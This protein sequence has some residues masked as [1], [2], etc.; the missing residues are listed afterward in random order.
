MTEF[1]R[2]D[3][4]QLASLSSGFGET[5][6][7]LE[8]AGSRQS[9]HMLLVRYLVE[10]WPDDLS[11]RDAAIAALDQ[12][13][14]QDAAIFDDLMRDPMVGAWLAAVTRKI[15]RPH[16]ERVP[17][18]GD[19]LHLG[20]LAAA[21]ALR[22]GVDCE[23]TGYARRGR[24]TLPGAGEAVLRPDTDGLVTMTVTAGSITLAAASDRITVPDDGDCWRP[25]RQLTAGR[26]AARLSVRIEDGN[27]YRGTYHAAP[28]GRLTTGEVLRWQ[29][30]FAAA[31]DLVRSCS[32]ERITEL[33]LGLR[34]VVPLV[35]SGDGAARS[36]TARDSVGAL[37]LTPP[38]AADDLLVTSIHEL[39][40]SKLSAVMD[41]VRLHSDDGVERHFAP[42]RTDARP[43]AALFQ[44]VYAFLGVAHVWHRLRQAS[45][46][47]R[48]AESEFANARVM[49]EQGMAALERSRELTPAGVRF[50]AG[51]RG[52][53]D[54]L[55]AEELPADALVAARSFLRAR[56]AS[57]SANKQTTE[58]R[59]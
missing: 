38:R 14:R 8:L 57:W 27:P 28:S 47:Q 29:G 26:G 34:A 3:D 21:G 22:A 55:L 24:V 40:H 32:P 37:G 39:Q 9:R 52:A 46:L 45:A 56:K 6:A 51:M 7:L 4:Q 18:A 16:G 35:D 12:V 10:A 25:L 31:Y 44:G 49:V 2:L 58:I 33:V 50:V 1:H 13:Q 36:G 17:R 42:W 54:A 19:F 53:L 11:G 30:L 48:R 5:S 15:A 41:L 59:Q 23:L 43:T 20:A